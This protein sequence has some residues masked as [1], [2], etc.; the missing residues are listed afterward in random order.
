MCGVGGSVITGTNATIEQYCSYMGEIPT[1]D[2]ARSN[3]PAVWINVFEYPSP[4]CEMFKR[5]RNSMDYVVFPV[6]EVD[7]LS[8]MPRAQRAAKYMTAMG[9]WRPPSGPG[10]SGPLPTPTCS[11]CM[12]CEYCFGR[13]E[14]SAQ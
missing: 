11:S 9:L 10:A 5:Y 3:R 2:W 13:K 8:V 14:L 1:E 12:N 6:E 4:A 7:R